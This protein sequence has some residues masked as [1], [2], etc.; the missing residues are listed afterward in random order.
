[1]P[2]RLAS[3]AQKIDSSGIRK[4]FDLAAKMK[5]PI[6][7]SIGQPHFDVPEPV[8]QAAIEAI[9]DGKNK[10]TLTQGTL[11][12]RSKV[13]K[14]LEK[15]RGGWSGEDVI[16]TSGTSGGLLLALL[17]T[18]EAGDEV[19]IADPYFVMYKHLVNLCAGTPVFVDTYPL[20]K[21]TP[22][23]LEAAVTAKTKLVLLNSPCNPTGIVYSKKELARLAAVLDKYELYAISDEIYDMFSYDGKFASLVDVYPDRTLLLGGFSKTWAMTGW[24]LGY[25]AG[26][27]D[28]IREMIKLQQYTFVNAPSMVQEAG[29]VA[30]DYDPEEFRQDYKRKRDLI[31]EG[32]V[33]SF[34]VEKPGG[35]FYIFPK[36]PWGT[37][38]SFVTR[39]IEKG[40]LVIPG[41]VFSEK[42]THFRISYATDERTIQR[43]VDVLCL[44]ADAGE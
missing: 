38:E 11:E 34:E 20:F 1:M 43:G 21:L 9:R 5:D 12:L 10:Y 19:I 6:N 31:Y 8:K 14:H 3:R 15:T 29:L 2:M 7:F 27:A 28:I 22:E 13:R 42:H 41:S 32:L 36:V 16:I 30:L 23:A 37:D 4:V 35:A 26:P 33:K 44:I 24:R 25:A 17:V 18:V 40:V 39:A